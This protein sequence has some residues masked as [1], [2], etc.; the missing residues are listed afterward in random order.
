MSPFGW[1]LVLI[2][3]LSLAL[4]PFLIIGAI[5]EFFGEPFKGT[6]T[7]IGC[8]VLIPMAVCFLYK[9][10]MSNTARGS[11]IFWIYCG[12]Y[13]LLFILSAS[14]LFADGLSVAGISG[15]LLLGAVSFWMISVAMKA[16]KQLAINLQMQYEA[17][18]E[19]DVRRQAEAILLAEKMKNEQK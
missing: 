7:V 18:R 8:Y 16:K 14:K 6:I 12:I 11:A 3:A 19:D 13:L 17:E 4:V 10:K 2:F 5:A 9:R 15:A 1:V